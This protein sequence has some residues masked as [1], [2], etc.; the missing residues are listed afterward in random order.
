MKE[1]EWKLLNDEG[2]DDT[3]TITYCAE[4]PNG[5][6]YRTQTR[7]L[8]PNDLVSLGIALA[9]APHPPRPT[10]ERED[11]DQSVSKVRRK[12]KKARSTR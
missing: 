9:F 5:L 7:E 2:D 12:K 8:G 3:Y 1:I 4:V 11:V 6:L 10:R